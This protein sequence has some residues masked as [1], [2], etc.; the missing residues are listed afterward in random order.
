M[1]IEDS[2]LLRMIEMDMAQ[3]GV[4]PSN[5]HIVGDYVVANPERIEVK[6]NEVVYICC[7]SAIALVQFEF[8][9]RYRSGSE[10]A[11]YTPDTTRETE[12]SGLGSKFIYDSTAISRHWSNVQLNAP[13]HFYIT[14]YLRYIKVV[15]NTSPSKP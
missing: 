9:I 3:K 13:Y 2:L 6:S 5:Y 7:F 10:V 4:S 12:V 15:Y 8:D 1:R 11:I 14:V